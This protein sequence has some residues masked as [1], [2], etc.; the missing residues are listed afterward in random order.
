MRV[1]EDHQE[2][3]EQRGEEVPQIR[4]GGRGYGTDDHVPE[5]PAAQGGDLGEDGDAEDVE[6]LADRQQGAGDGEDEDAD[7]V[8][9]V[10]DGRAEQLLEHPYILTQ[11]KAPTLQR[12]AGA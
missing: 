1:E 8:E 2:R 5:Q 3:G 11:Q 4:E 7:Q 10:L 12:K 6:V 9:R